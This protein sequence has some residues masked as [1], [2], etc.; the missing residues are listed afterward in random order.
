[1]L[2][3]AHSAILA[4]VACAAVSTFGQLSQEGQGVFSANCAQCHGPGGVGGVAPSLDARL[5]RYYQN[6]DQLYDKIRFDMPKDKPGQLTTI[7][8][9]Q[10][11]SYILVKNGYVGSQDEFKVG[12]LS[13]IAISE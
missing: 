13:Q 12:A 4:L 10:V 6:A 5:G 11:L 2:P 7:S 9:Q 8:Y 3:L 1:V